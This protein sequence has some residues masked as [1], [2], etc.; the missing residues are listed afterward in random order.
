MSREPRCVECDLPEFHTTERECIAALKARLA[1]KSASPFWSVTLP[2]HGMAAD[3]TAARER[4]TAVIGE[5]QRF[6]PPGSPPSGDER[7]LVVWICRTAE[8]RAARA[9]TD[10]SEAKLALESMNKSR[11]VW[12]DR[13]DNMAARVAPL[14]S[15]LAVAREALDAFVN[16]AAAS[17]R[18]SE[19]AAALPTYRKLITARAVL[20]G[21]EEAPVPAR[22]GQS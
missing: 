17:G 10:A 20:A 2:S 15:D 8:E 9:E 12:W 14:E 13:H 16:E 4:L 21:R 3:L 6:Q 1:R 18:Q 5:A 19:L 7:V 11:D 22:E